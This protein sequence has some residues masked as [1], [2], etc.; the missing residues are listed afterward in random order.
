MSK[1]FIGRLESGDLRGS[2]AAVARLVEALGLAFAIVVPEEDLGASW[3]DAPA[4][5]QPGA[6]PWHEASAGHGSFDPAEVADAGDAGDA[7]CR[8]PTGA[9]A[10]FSDDTGDRD[11]I[12]GG[13]DDGDGRDDESVDA[14]DLEAPTAATGREE[15]VAI[16]LPAAWRSLRTD[17]FYADPALQ[18][19]AESWVRRAE[20][21]R[22]R[23]AA[24]RR[25]PAHVLCFPIQ[26]P[27]T[28]WYCRH[29]GWRWERRPI[30]SWR[31]DPLWRRE[32]ELTG[33]NPPPLGAHPYG[34][35]PLQGWPS[36]ATRSEWPPEPAVLRRARWARLR[37]DEGT[38]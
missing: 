19:V 36:E 26:L 31:R 24:G 13:S 12:G 32:V 23:D 20:A 22:V 34:G 33:A 27:R 8:P 28:W 35:C 5:A 6:D 14:D 25:M 18:V 15:R 2:A 29:V 9:A 10:W 4:P 3:V 37:P 11:A 7:V 38:R 30:W 17:R 16:G 21:E 1:S